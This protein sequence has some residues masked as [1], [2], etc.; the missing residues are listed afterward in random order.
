MKLKVFGLS[1][2]VFLAMNSFAQESEKRFGF[3]LNSGLSAATK[4][5]NGASLNTGLGFEGLLHYRF[6]PHLGV[7][8]G[9]GWNRFGTDES[10]TSNDFSYEETGYIFGLNFKHP[11]GNSNL[12]YYVRGGALYNHIETDDSNGETIHD[13]KHGFGFQLAGGLVIDLGRN[14]NFTPG[15]KFN[16]LARETDFEGMSNKLICQYIS[17]RIGFAKN[18]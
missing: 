2:L 13:S 3:E 16:S 10:F 8:A 15:V 6:M 14:W 18:F 17:V 5:I 7:Y 1:M 9:W 4:K 12:G 11:I